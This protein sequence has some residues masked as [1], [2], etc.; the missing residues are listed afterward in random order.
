MLSASMSMSRSIVKKFRRLPEVNVTTQIHANSHGIFHNHTRD[1][2]DSN[3]LFHLHIQ[4][5]YTA[6]SE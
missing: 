2:D 4:L 3:S 1:Y 5:S 6:S